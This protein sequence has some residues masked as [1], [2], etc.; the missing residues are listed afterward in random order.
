MDE[1]C[2]HMNNMMVDDAVIKKPSSNNDTDQR[3]GIIIHDK[4]GNFL[5]LRGSKSGQFSFPKGHIKAGESEIVAAWREASEEVGL[6]YENCNIHFIKQIKLRHATYFHYLY[7][8]SYN[9]LYLYPPT[10]PEETI[11]IKWVSCTYLA[12]RHLNE[13]SIDLKEFVLENVNI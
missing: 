12:L 4:N 7:N 1:L 2:E 9:N 13:M 6:R 5:I 11:E 8:D 3:A 10:T